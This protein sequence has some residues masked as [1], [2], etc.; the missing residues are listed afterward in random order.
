MGNSLTN[1]DNDD[2]SIIHQLDERLDR[3]VRVELANSSEIGHFLEESRDEA[4]LLVEQIGIELKKTRDPNQYDSLVSIYN[5]WNSLY[6]YYGKSL[7]NKSIKKDRSYDPKVL[8][9]AENKKLVRGIVVTN[10]MD[11]TLVVQIRRKVKHSPTGK[12]IPKTT[13]I[14]VHDE[15]NLCSIGQE[16]LAIET[17]PISKTKFHTLYSRVVG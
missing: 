16:I 10:R 12:Y 13:K 14:K 15:F 8:A 17:R 2:G 11:K 3:K 5:K 9:R 7:S 1:R 6:A 4:N